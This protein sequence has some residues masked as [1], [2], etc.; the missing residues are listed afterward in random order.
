MASDPTK[1]PRHEPKEVPEPRTITLTP[2]H[3]KQMFRLALARGYASRGHPLGHPL[4]H[5]PTETKAEDTGVD[6]DAVDIDAIGSFLSATSRL[7]GSSST[8]YR[9]SRQ[10]YMEI[11]E[12]VVREA[13]P[14][15]RICLMGG[16]SYPALTEAVGARLGITP[17][18]LVAKP[19]SSGEPHVIVQDNVRG[20]DV[21]ILQSIGRNIGGCSTNYYYMELKL[22]IDA[23]RRSNARSITVVV[24]SYP[25]ARQDKK[26]QPR[27]PITASLVARELEGVGATRVITFDLHSAQIQGFF[28]IPMDNL[29]A[30]DLLVTRLKKPDL[31]VSPDTH[32]LISPDNGGSKRVD[33]YAE[34]LKLSSLTR[35]KRRDHRGESVIVKS[36]LVGD[37]SLLKD[38]EAI[39]VDD[40]ID[41]AGTMV[42]CV[43]ELVAQGIRSV[44]L[45]ITHGIFSGPGVTRLMECPH[46]RKV[47]CTNTLPMD[48]PGFDK[49]EV[50]DIS[51]MVGDVLECI[52]TG[53]SVSKFFSDS[54]RVRHRFC[55]LSST[56]HASSGSLAKDEPSQVTPNVIVSPENASRFFSFLANTPPSPIPSTHGVRNTD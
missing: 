28:Q 48:F 45:V 49:L 46:I 53:K 21:I 34:K 5:F 19:F 27:V 26:D 38:K 22:I 35:D 50:V 43:E 4:G 33:A 23:C 10:D 56:S 29:Y 6:I 47:I 18:P 11:L 25:Y 51:E 9:L 13:R 31:G 15:S 24:P 8:P 42:T 37:L 17:V 39:I 41:T 36:H 12:D 20:M 54:T 44:I 2:D 7:F 52:Y 16:S 30:I 14:L 40:M 55:S 1:T 32:V 3:A